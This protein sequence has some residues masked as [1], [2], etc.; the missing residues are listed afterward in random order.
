M[1]LTDWAV[2][3]ARQVRR[4]PFAR[5]V[6]RRHGRARTAAKYLWRHA[7][8]SPI[9]LILRPNAPS[10]QR[11]APIF[12]RR[13]P[14]ATKFAPRTGPDECD[15][16]GLGSSG[17]HHY[18]QKQLYFAAKQPARNDGLWS[19]KKPRLC[20]RYSTPEHSHPSKRLY[21]ILRVRADQSCETD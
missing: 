17:A 8:C 9:A 13:P 12:M 1:P 14:N 16:F 11:S 20:A 2:S 6:G 3:Q 5:G 4:L 10:H 7:L 19:A 21:I 15:L 18:P